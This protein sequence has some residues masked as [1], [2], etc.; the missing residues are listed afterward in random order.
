MDLKAYLLTEVILCFFFLHYE[1][2]SF[3]IRTQI[4]SEYKLP[5]CYRATEQMV[6]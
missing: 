3:L 2:T 6:T 1:W 4:E 5:H